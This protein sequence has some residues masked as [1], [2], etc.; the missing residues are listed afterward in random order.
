MFGSNTSP[1]IVV[2]LLDTAGAKHFSLYGYSRPTTP[3]IE[4]ISKSATVYTNCF[5]PAPW[6]LP[7]HASLFTGLFPS[8]HMND[9]TNMKI[10][11]N[12][13]T[14]PEIL[15]E[16]GYHTCGISANPILTEEFCYG[17][18]SFWE[19]FH[20]FKE[21]DLMKEIKL[22]YFWKT[23]PFVALEDIENNSDIIEQLIS[24]PLERLSAADK[25]NLVLTAARNTIGKKNQFGAFIKVLLNIMTRKNNNIVFDATT[26]TL[27]I[28]KI[29]DKQLRRYAKEKNPFFLFI[30]FMQLHD[31]Y[32]PPKETRGAFAEDNRDYESAPYDLLD[33]YAVKP[34]PN[35]F[36]S[37]LESKYDEELLYLDG[38]VEK[39]NT[40]LQSLNL[41]DNTMLIITSDHGEAF[42][43]HGQVQHLFSTYNE[44]IH[45]PLII[46][47]PDGIKAPGIDDRLTQLH[48]IYATV[49]EI[50]GTP[51]PSPDSSVSLL[52]SSGRSMA[53]SQLLDVEHKLVGCRIKN[54]NFDADNFEYD[55]PEM[56]II[57]E[58]MHKLIHRGSKHECY[59]LN[60]G[61]YETD[62]LAGQDEGK[63]TIEKL[64]SMM[65][66]AKQRLG[67]ADI[68]K[69]KEQDAGNLLSPGIR[70]A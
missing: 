21:C 35:E 18:D 14:L 50:A 1:N 62:N 22:K 16:S 24:E 41:S 65:E 11:R 47:Y 2:L 27:K 52:N 7:A 57:S 30:N 6:T 23:D 3:D 44:L 42:G 45:I 4:R 26:S 19:A 59:D 13:Y 31:R 33:H 28:L 17:F 63:K 12:L 69:E 70:E 51:F 20:L 68:M 48:D 55:A 10:H 56:S 64:T 54:K 49:N 61:Y 39:I 25:L 37:Y 46:K 36:L 40:L 66:Q 58:D 29:A 5:S 53:V 32:N 38:V 8:Q 43:E 60:K 9:G 15:R 34:F 67:Y